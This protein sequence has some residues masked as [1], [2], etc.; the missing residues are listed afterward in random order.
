M[1]VETIQNAEA[2]AASELEGEGTK[3][4]MADKSASMVD[5]VNDDGEQKAALQEDSA[6]DAIYK[7][8][9]EKRQDALGIEPEGQD[10][11]PESNPDAKP[12]DEE[13]TVKVNG[14]ERQVS[15]AKIEAAG[16]SAEVIEPKEQ[17]RGRIPK[18]KGS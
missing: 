5:V 16:G 2:Q 8:H 7:K 11:K 12:E 4:E 15:R 18:K 1:S 14:K 9:S 13:I 3:V 6:R 17:K 10:T